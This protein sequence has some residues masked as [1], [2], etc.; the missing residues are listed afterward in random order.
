M[1]ALFGCGNGGSLAMAFGYPNGLRR[2]GNEFHGYVFMALGSSIE[3]S[4]VQRGPMEP[5]AVR[6]RSGIGL[7]PAG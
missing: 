6:P 3:S 2:Y 5:N 7:S 1:N 4:G